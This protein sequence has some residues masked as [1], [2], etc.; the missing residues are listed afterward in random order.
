MFLPWIARAA[1]LHG[2]RGQEA[3]ATDGNPHEKPA[4]PD[5]ENYRAA[6]A[7]NKDTGLFD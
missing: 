1:L 5:R 7:R 3:L 2:P 6:E 4:S